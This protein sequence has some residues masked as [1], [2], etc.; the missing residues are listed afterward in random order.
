MELF[1]Y[2]LCFVSKWR[3][4]ESRNEWNVR[5][6]NI[7]Y[8]QRGECIFFKLSVMFFISIQEIHATKSTFSLNSACFIKKGHKFIDFSL[9]GH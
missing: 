3:L 2:S 6:S 5:F 4:K 7:L 8:D 1:T 9:I